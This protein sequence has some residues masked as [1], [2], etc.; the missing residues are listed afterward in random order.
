MNSRSK[1]NRFKG[2][3]VLVALEL[4]VILGT[5]ISPPDAISEIIYSLTGALLFA[6]G[7]CVI[8]WIIKKLHCGHSEKK[9]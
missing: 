5:V 1:S 4:G 7:V 3:I 2:I 9:S 8:F 6:A